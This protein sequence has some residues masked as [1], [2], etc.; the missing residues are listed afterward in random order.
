M[1]R[2]QK[3]DI[4]IVAPILAVALVFLAMVAGP[5]LP[6][7]TA[8]AQTAADD[9]DAKEAQ[10]Q[11]YLQ[12]AQVLA[13]ER[14]SIHQNVTNY[15]KIKTNTTSTSEL[16]A[17]NQK[18][19][20]DITRADQIDQQIASIE[21]LNKALYVVDPAFESQLYSGQSKLLQKYVNPSTTSLPNNP[22]DDVIVDILHK[23]IVIVVN[24]D[25]LAADKSNYPTETTINGIPVK[26]I[27][28][29]EYNTS[30]SPDNPTTGQCRPIWGGISVADASQ[31]VGTSTNTIGYKATRSG[32]VGFVVAGHT[33]VGLNHVMD[34]PYTSTSRVGVV[35][36]WEQDL[37]C[38]CAW[39][40][41]D[42]GVSVDHIIY[43]TS[44]TATYAV[45][46]VTAK[47]SQ[48]VGSFVYESSA[49]SGLRMGQIVNNSG[50][51]TRV[52]IQMLA[53]GG[54]SGS[55]IFTSC[56]CGGSWVASLYGEATGGLPTNPPQTFYYPQD[57][58][59][60]QIG[61]VPSTS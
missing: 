15:E 51:T 35:N 12:E 14:E 29:K 30:C 44:S 19:K 27:E 1:K 42:S 50:G 38:D 23:N 31:P 34:Q 36:A 20:D 37:T 7:I 26:V 54:D 13:N 47:S 39:V 22:V 52:Y 61:A 33:G 32:Q 11:K 25:K 6:V 28:S 49:F 45:I 3:G 57:I 46:S 40:K 18:I 17:L 4:S 16:Q 21:N 55:P 58:V 41:A 2:N 5:I 48:T 24:P 53:N 60:I 8:N 59:Q 9:G 10:S 43:G 56:S